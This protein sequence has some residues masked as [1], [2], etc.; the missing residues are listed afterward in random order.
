MLLM[1]QYG[2]LLDNSFH[3]NDW[4]AAEPNKATVDLLEFTEEQTWVVLTNHLCHW[5]YADENFDLSGTFAYTFFDNK[6]DAYTEW[7][8]IDQDK[9]LEQKSHN[10]S[11]LHK[12]RNLLGAADWKRYY[13]TVFGIN[14]PMWL[15][16]LQEPERLEA[17]CT[18]FC[19]YC[20]EV[21]AQWKESENAE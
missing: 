17:M 21:I 11:I 9:L 3:A 13:R 7:L 4:N 20:D 18:D 15:Q 8:R 1:F 10:I 14:S 16:L 5:N 6:E 2:V 12:W 19:T